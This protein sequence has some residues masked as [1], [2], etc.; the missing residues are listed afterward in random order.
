MTNH[1]DNLGALTF[2]ISK[3]YIQSILVAFLAAIGFISYVIW[4]NETPMLSLG[5]VGL[6]ALFT[7]VFG[8]YFSYI[9]SYRVI[10]DTKKITIRS[11]FASNSTSLE[12]LNHYSHLKGI[13]YLNTT[14]G[15]RITISSYLEHM[16]LFLNW[17]DH[18][19]PSP[20]K[21]KELQRLKTARIEFEQNEL[22]GKSA[23][24]REA[25]LK[26]ANKVV[27]IL[28]GVTIINVLLFFYC[29]FSSKSS[30]YPFLVNL[31]TPIICLSVLYYFKGLVTIGLDYNKINV[32]PNLILPLSFSSILV[33]LYPSLLNIHF[34]N[35]NQL[36]S[37][38]LLL[39]IAFTLLF[40]LASREFQ[41]KKVKD[42]LLPI[43]ILLTGSLVYNYG[44][45][46]FFNVY[47][48]TS[49]TKAFK[50]AVLNKNVEKEKNHSIQ[51]SSWYHQATNNNIPVPK[52]LYESVQVNDSVLIVV[53]SGN[54]GLEY[55]WIENLNR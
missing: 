35:Y 40:I 24:E 34:V 23:S 25:N 52:Y 8:L 45:I 39:S 1:L 15:S 9:L 29:I 19:V 7:I 51:V 3:S 32:Q 49:E 6:Y 13:L 38:N 44:T 4:S 54:L 18:Y 55:Y 17:L 22:Y 33:A 47:K 2:K 31:S 26:K 43:C 42:L 20:E 41:L 50:V 21:E 48:D 36:L 5:I 16:D 14:D 10:V 53:S 30:L 12:V 46:S 28:H 37:Y 11:L 27:L